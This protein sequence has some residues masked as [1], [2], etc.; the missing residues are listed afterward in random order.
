MAGEVV[1]RPD[2]AVGNWGQVAPALIDRVHREAV[3]GVLDPAASELLRELH[4]D[5]D[6]AEA[7]R[8]RPSD[9]PAGPVIDLH[10]Q[11]DL[12]ILRFFSVVSTI[13]TPIDVTAQEPR[14]EAFFPSDDATRELW[15][16]R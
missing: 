3:E 8:R 16:S 14:V 2:E 6:V 5:R 1:D 13:G 15:S 4:Q 9:E 10:F 11:V 12:G 7:L